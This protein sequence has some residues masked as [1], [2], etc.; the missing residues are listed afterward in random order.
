MTIDLQTQKLAE[1][2]ILKEFGKTP[3]DMTI[4]E[5]FMALS[6]VCRK[7]YTMTECEDYLAMEKASLQ[8]LDCNYLTVVE[9]GNQH[10]VN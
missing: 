5:I 3:Q 4:D 8:L 6:V 7:L 10:V 1:E 2:F 9:S